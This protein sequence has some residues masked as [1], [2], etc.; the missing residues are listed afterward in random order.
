MVP[1][2]MI[3]RL[4]RALTR[5]SVDRPYLVVGLFLALFAVGGFTARRLELRLNYMEL[6]P[7]DA[8]EVVD[9]KWVMKKAGTEGYLVVE[10]AG[11]T[12]EERL[13]VVPELAVAIE[14]L[15]EVRY[16]E[17]RYD[18]PF[19]RQNIG[20]F[21]EMEDLVRLRKE[22]DEKVKAGLEESF[23]LGLDDEKPK[24]KIDSAA[25]DREI[26]KIEAKI[27]SE[28]IEDEQKQHLYLLA[29]PAL[30]SMGM[31]EVTQM[32]T[33][34]E[35][36][37]KATIATS[38][39]PLTVAFGG[40]A[41]F[42][43]A[44]NDGVT[45]DLGVIS[46]VALTASALLLLLATRRPLAALFILLPIAGAISCALGMAAI[47]IGH[48]NIISSLLV[49]ILLGLGVEFGI[50][51]IL[52]TSEARETLPLRDALLDA[53]PETM[54]GAFTG[55]VTNAAAFGVLLFASFSAYRQFGGIAAAGILMS[56]LF[57]YSLLPALI[58]IT[59]RF[60]PESV[61]RRRADR[62]ARFLVPR[63][64][65][66]VLVLALPAFAVFGA[67]S[68]RHVELERSFN[69]LNGDSVP[70]P[71]GGR[72][73]RAMKSTLTP[74]FI[75]V[76][77]LEQARRVEEIFAELKQADKNPQGSIIDST[78]SLARVIRDDWEP[79]RQELRAIRK[80]LRRLPDD[81]REKHKARLDDFEIATEAEP[82]RLDNLPEQMRRK[83][84]PLD[85]QGT[86][87]LFIP[88]RSVDDSRELDDF[89]DKLELAVAR[90]GKEG[91][92][93]RVMSENRIAVH[94]F[95]Q[96]FADTPFIAWSATLVALGVLFLLLRNVKETLVV[97]APL[98]IGM[99]GMVALMYLFGVKLNFIN[100]CVIPSIFTIAIDNTVHLY[101]RYVKEGPR[102][103]PHIFATTGQAVL[104]ASLVN[105]SGYVPMLLADFYGLRSLGYLASFGMLGMVLATVVWFPALLG[106]MPEGFLH[107]P[108]TPSQRMRDLEAEA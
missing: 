90:A 73:A 15:P 99:L 13:D 66:W 5:L 55:A 12:R 53:V 37:A 79:R 94:I 103:L 84:T 75:W 16:A 107:E 76:E 98:A 36:A 6:L 57:T 4:A 58:V 72:G 85:G 83:F 96:V 80:D 31:V 19:F 64:V 93:T 20:A 108:P 48:L 46:V 2:L 9:L 87:V 47:T 68:L 88:S 69:A 106:L 17:Y 30:A 89:V 32:L 100:M 45:K 97:F 11:G 22:L 63:R 43:K 65:L 54:D 71:V 52:R 33:K 86:F 41:V 59:E 23:D 102:A 3:E 26:A 62:A 104:M 60:F 34:V 21:I 56:W 67:W 14:A 40:P 42:M 29:K 28:F 77:G 101:H 70:D 8:P 1:G 105:A 24:S 18:V 74:A 92:K 61:I 44:M 38:G 27:P 50:H 91:I 35:G 7:E 39:K 81:L 49:A 10:L 25:V 82:L 51:L 95:R 78:L